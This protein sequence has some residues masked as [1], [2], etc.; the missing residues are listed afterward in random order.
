MFT[1]AVTEFTPNT[2]GIN[3]LGGNVWEWCMDSVSTRSELMA[4]A[5]GGSFAVSPNYSL[6]EPD[7][8][9]LGAVAHPLD[10]A[11]VYRSSYRHFG[12]PEESLKALEKI[13]TSWPGTVPCGGVRIVTATAI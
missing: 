5:R 1:S 9:E 7:I 11:V 8:V 3:D 4:V 12:K 2:L 6:H 10:N 13:G